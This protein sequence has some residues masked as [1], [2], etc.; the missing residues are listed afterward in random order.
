MSRSDYGPEGCGDCV[1]GRCDMN[2]G[3]A[4][5]VYPGVSLLTPSQVVRQHDL[6][7]DRKRRESTKEKKQRDRERQLRQ[8]HEYV[9]IASVLGSVDVDLVEPEEVY[10]I[11]TAIFHYGRLAQ[12]LGETT[13]P[14]CRA[15]WRKY[16]EEAR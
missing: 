6:T 16:L 9:R 4:M 13:N 14:A 12:Q 1:N 15:A 11:V 10:T 8:L 2:C 5:T 7:A 3:P